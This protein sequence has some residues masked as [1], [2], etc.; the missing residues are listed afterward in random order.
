MDKA[1][2][3]AE[4][5]LISAEAEAKAPQTPPT[6]SHRAEV[7]PP[8]YNPY[9]SMMSPTGGRPE[10][11]AVPPANAAQRRPAAI[12]HPGEPPKP[13]VPVRVYLRVPDLE[14]EIYKKAE[15]LVMIFCDGNTETVFYDESAKK[16]VKHAVKV[17]LTSV[18]KARLV[19]I[20]GEENVVVK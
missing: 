14:G 17:R 3:D 16:Y 5:K 18:V 11:R 6:T 10:P 8:V 7:S 15:N 12:E 2:A 19:R 20:L 13:Q 1:K 9:E 4:A